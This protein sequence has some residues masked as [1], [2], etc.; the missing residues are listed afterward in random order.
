MESMH[1]QLN[2]TSGRKMET[3]IE[4]KIPRLSDQ[5]NTKMNK[6]W[7]IDM[8]IEERRVNKT[9]ICNLKLQISVEIC[10]QEW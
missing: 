5:I 4:E 9:D 2:V 8:N 6:T 7:L 1:I 3:K 10:K